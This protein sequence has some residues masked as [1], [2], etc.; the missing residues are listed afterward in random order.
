MFKIQ[1]DYYED[2]LPMNSPS[3]VWPRKKV[4]II[5]IIIIGHFNLELAQTSDFIDWSDN[6]CHNYP[7]Y[8]SIPVSTKAY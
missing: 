5:I 4:V 2:G 7:F 8:A 6:S 3:I 1:N